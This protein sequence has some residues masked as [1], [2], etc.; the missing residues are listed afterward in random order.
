MSSTQTRSGFTLIEVL[1][2]VGIISI[3]SSL[4]YVNFQTA[5][6][7][8]RVG[9]LQASLKEVQLAIEVFKAQNGRYPGTCNDN[10][11]VSAKSDC[12]TSPTVK[13]LIPYYIDAIP[14]PADSP[15]PACDI[16]YEVDDSSSASWYKLSAVNCHIGVQPVG[17]LDE[18]TFCP[19]SCATTAACNSDTDR[20]ENSYAIY[21]PGGECTA[22]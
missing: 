13:E 2:V 18:L 10:N 19:Q 16:T 9:A 6:E 5:R 20:K 22:P 1:V 11:Q 3:L 12:G 14:M 4:L 7:K 15:N 8:A 17:P 21:S